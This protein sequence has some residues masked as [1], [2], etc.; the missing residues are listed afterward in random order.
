MIRDMVRAKPL[1][2]LLFI[3]GSDILTAYVLNI[4]HQQHFNVTRDYLTI[5]KLVGMDLFS[6]IFIMLFLD[7]LH[8]K[9]FAGQPENLFDKITRI[10]GNILAAY[11]GWFSV[12]YMIVQGIYILRR[13]FLGFQ[14][15]QLYI[16]IITAGVAAIVHF[17]L[18]R[19]ISWRFQLNPF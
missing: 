19:K 11:F 7:W 13:Q 4:I 8:M 5:L 3:L 14:E 1:S 17:L 16:L 10:G 9:F 6:F 12:L 18:R 15:T 2:W